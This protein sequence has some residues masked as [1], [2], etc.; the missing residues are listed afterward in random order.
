VLTDVR[1]QGRCFDCNCYC[2][3]VVTAS[4]PIPPTPAFRLLRF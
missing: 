3:I 1:G 2:L 4:G